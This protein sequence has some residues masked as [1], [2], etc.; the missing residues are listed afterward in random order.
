LLLDLRVR[1]ELRADLLAELVL[2]GDSRCALPA[3]EELL[4]VPVILFQQ[5]QCVH[6]GL[7]RRLG[8][9]ARKT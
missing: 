2:L 1:R 3:L 4:D 6:F 8:L 9:W 5:V 7:L